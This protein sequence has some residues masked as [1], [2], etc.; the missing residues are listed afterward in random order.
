VRLDL[1]FTISELEV[2]AIFLFVYFLH[3]SLILLL[4]ISSL[5]NRFLKFIPKF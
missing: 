1:I 4:V 5:I 2:L 3:T